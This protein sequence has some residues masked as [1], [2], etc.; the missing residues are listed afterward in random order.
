VSRTAETGEARLTADRTMA[1]WLKPAPLFLLKRHCG[2]GKTDYEIFSRAN[3]RLTWQNLPARVVLR[4]LLGWAYRFPRAAAGALRNHGAETR[5]LF[6]RSFAGQFADMV[7]LTNRAGMPPS[8]YYDFGLARFGGSAK[9]RDFITDNFYSSVTRAASQHRLRTFSDAPDIADKIIFER[10]CVRIGAA[11]VKTL[12]VVAE[13]RVSDI[14]GAPCETEFGD[15]SLFVKPRGAQQGVGAQRFEALGEGLYRATDGSTLSRAALLAHLSQVSRQTKRELLLQQEMRNSA[16]VEALVGRALATIRIIT[17][18]DETDA[19]E[20]VYAALRSGGSAESIVDNYHA[21]GVAFSLDIE[22]GELGTGRR[23]HFTAD[24]QFY[25]SHPVTG[26]MIAGTRLPGWPDAKALAI[27]LHRA[28]PHS[29]VVGWDIAMTE[30]GACA[31]EANSPPGIPIVQMQRGFL[32]T[33][34]A[35]LLAWHVDRWLTEDR[36][37]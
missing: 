21:Q 33:R 36:S 19:P 29:L 32:G 15:R 12:A 26:A 4:R 37:P 31:V 20:V 6:G 22:T 9:L 5:R 16:T 3:A 18:P 1:P 27:R 28:S 8:E 30:D 11:S 35:A 10:L 24:P 7:R 17:L 13:D 2:T 14:F 25:R 34:Y 23:L